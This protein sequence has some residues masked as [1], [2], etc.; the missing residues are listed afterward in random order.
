MGVLQIGSVPKK[1]DTFFIS[2]IRDK[3]KRPAEISAGLFLFFNLN[4]A[5]VFV[6]L[7]ETHATLFSTKNITNFE[8]VL[9]GKQNSFFH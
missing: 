1:L 3:T 9:Y 5:F 8:G 2:H 6:N 7:R 4:E